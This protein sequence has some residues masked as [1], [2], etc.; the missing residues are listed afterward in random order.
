MP[1]LRGLGGGL[2]EAWSPFYL[3]FE[4]FYLN[5]QCVCVLARLAT[6]EAGINIKVRVWLGVGEG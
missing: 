4:H 6:Q 5:V 2:I 3:N 1:D